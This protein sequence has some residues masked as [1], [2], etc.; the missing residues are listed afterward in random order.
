ML[1]SCLA[2]SVAGSVVSQQQVHLSYAGSDGM[3]VAY[4]TAE[5]EPSIVHFGIAGLMHNATGSPSQYLKNHGWH[6]HVTLTGLKPAQTYVY[7]AG[8]QAGQPPRS[9]QTAAADPDVPVSLSIFGDMGYLNSSVRHMWIHV[10]GLKTNW[11]ASHTRDTVLRL[12]ENKSVDFAWHL[13]DV[14]YADDG[15]SHSPFGFRYEQA[16]NGFMEWIEPI[17]SAVPYM[18]APG[19]HESECHSPAC[20]VKL[21]SLGKPLSNFT[22]YTHRWA[23]PY[24]QSGGTSNMWYSF[25]TGPVHF[26]SANTETDWHGAPE[27]SRGDSGLLPAGSFGTDGEYMAWLEADLKEADAA[28]RQPNGR[29]WIVVGGHRPFYEINASHGALF[30]RYGVDAYFSGHHHAYARTTVAPKRPAAQQASRT[31]SAQS[32]AITSSSWVEAAPGTPGSMLSVVVGGAGCEEMSQGPPSNATGHGAPAFE[33]GR[34]ASGVLTVSKTSLVW[35]LIDSVS[36]TIIDEA[37]LKK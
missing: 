3:V 7:A 2:A 16:Y 33:T 15:F 34:Y 21:H 24:A 13:G 18:V 31:S 32:P 6:H 20:I 12:V 17:A 19:N 8:T 22:A 11:S 28:R 14:G 27:E 9:F 23:M 29:P 37:S 5:H 26:V 1:A 30:A 25:D 35:R 36:G 4:F 10:A